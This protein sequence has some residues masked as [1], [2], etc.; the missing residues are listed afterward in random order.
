VTNS[1][2]D[3]NGNLVQ[4]VV[5]EP[6]ADPATGAVVR[7][8]VFATTFTYDELDRAV[9]VTDSATGSSVRPTRSV[10]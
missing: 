2:Y 9:S 5:Q 8:E 7:Y 4:K 3:T 6:V 1:A 10:T